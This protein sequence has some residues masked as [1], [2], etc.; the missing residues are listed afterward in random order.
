MTDIHRRATGTSA[1]T[2]N[3]CLQPVLWESYVYTKVIFPICSRHT[4]ATWL[5]AR[6]KNTD[7]ESND[8]RT[9]SP[10]APP[11]RSTGTAQ[12]SGEK[13]QEVRLHDEDHVRFCAIT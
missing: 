6:D 13:A 12:K 7:V 3:Y 1:E 10:G 4:P 9:T 5:S 8:P 11:R 2:P